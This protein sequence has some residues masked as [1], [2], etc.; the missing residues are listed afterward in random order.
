MEEAPLSS[1]EPR[2]NLTILMMVKN[3]VSTIERAL[4][5]L[6]GIAD[7][8]CMHDTGSADNTVDFTSRLCQH[9]G[10]QFLCLRSSIEHSADKYFLDEQKSFGD[11]VVES[12]AANETSSRTSQESFT[13]QP[14]LADWAWGFNE[15]LSLCQAPYVLRLDADDVALDPYN[16][17]PTLQ[18]LDI[19]PEVD[20][21][22]CPYE[23]WD[24]SSDKMAYLYMQDR[25][26]RRGNVKYERVMHEKLTP[27][28]NNW[29]LA[30]AGLRFRDMRDSKGDGVRIHGRNAKVLVR[31]WKR[32]VQLGMK[33]D[34]EFLFTM[35]HELVNHDPMWALKILGGLVDWNRLPGFRGETLYHMG[36]AHEALGDP[37]AAVKHYTL[38][39]ESALPSADALLRRGM[40]TESKQDLL[41][42]EALVKRM[43]GCNTDLLLLERAKSLLTTMA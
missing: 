27:K 25:I 17:L 24:P 39:I 21:V 14:V 34:S 32:Q 40:L 7:E 10:I 43:G 9:L 23:I 31:E 6:K 28:A 13:G 37:Q 8:V 36:R 42:G 22:S 4:T 38:A 35:G 19:R 16:I 2:M 29:I 3:G 15:A 18:M 1:E 30:A 5:P 41:D 26:W 20:I 12:W 33:V 11:V